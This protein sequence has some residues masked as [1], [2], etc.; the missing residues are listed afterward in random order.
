MFLNENMKLLFLYSSL[1]L[2]LITPNIKYGTYGIPIKLFFFFF[3]IPNRER[4]WH[5]M[6]CCRRRYGHGCPGLATGKET[7]HYHRHTWSS[8]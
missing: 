6:L 5:Q 7:S 4:N 8:R 2:S 3:M 1:P